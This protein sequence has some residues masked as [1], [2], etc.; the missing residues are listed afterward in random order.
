MTQKQTILEILRRAGT[1]GVNSYG[2]ARDIAL[3]LPV[4]IKELKETGYTIVS[5]REKDKSVTYIL[6]KEKLTN[7]QPH[8]EFKWVTEGNIAKQIQVNLKPEQLGID[9][10]G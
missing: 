5:R 4:R 3:Q 7:S 6:L 10:A 9:L 8:A 2:F 1:M